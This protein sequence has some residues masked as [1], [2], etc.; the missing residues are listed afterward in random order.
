MACISVQGLTASYSKSK[1]LDNIDLEFIQ[2]KVTA[3]VGPNGSGKSTLLKAIAGSMKPDQGI[4]HIN[5]QNMHSLK[6]KELAKILAF[7][8]QSPET[9][10]DI[11][12]EQ[13]VSYGRYSHQNL[14]KN[15]KFEDKKII[16]WALQATDLIQLSQSSM[17]ELSGGQRQRAWIA[18]A[19]AQNSDCLFLDE[20]TTYLDIRHQIEILNLLKSLNQEKS[21]TIIMVLHDINH[22]L[23]YSDYIVVVKNGKIFAHDCIESIVENK[24]LENV[25]KVKFK[26][27]YD[28]NK[29]PFIV[30]NELI[31]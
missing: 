13:L 8:P 29:K 18:M 17:S 2:K 1:I 21:K 4:V 16:D 3:I 10:K 31:N 27:L 14:F 9:P 19:L 28:E 12:I 11:T 23:H 24:V 15:T 5:G 25:F 20:V 7:L 26:V 30:S 6:K 22:A